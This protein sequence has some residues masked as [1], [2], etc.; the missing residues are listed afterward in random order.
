MG[1]NNFFDLLK[2]AVDKVQQD[3]H[4]NPEERT[5]PTNLFDRIRENLAKS[6]ER[7]KENEEEG[8]GLFD[9][10]R[11]K[12][13]EAQRDNEAD[14]EEETA[15]PTVFEKLQA[16]LKRLE[17]EKEMASSGLPQYGPEPA[18]EGY[19]EYGPDPEPTPPPVRPSSKPVEPIP[20]QR[21]DHIPNSVPDPVP[22]PSSKPRAIPPSMRSV[23]SSGS[24]AVRTEP[25][26]AAPQLPSRIPAKAK[27]RVLEHSMDN[28]IKLDGKLTGWCLV[29]YEN[30]RGWV[31]DYYVS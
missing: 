14:P 21:I 1:K 29:D 17:E 24:I 4:D 22:A 8:K 31:L 11:E 20:S 3:N 23:V 25:N 26:M 9:I 27:L 18:P 6:K 12:L 16:E 2:N 19:V 7:R 13:Q 5:A 30:I 10:F 28:A 15:E